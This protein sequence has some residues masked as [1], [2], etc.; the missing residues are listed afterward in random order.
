M[1][2]VASAVMH[3]EVKSVPP[4]MTLAD[5]ET[6]LVS[7]GVSGFAVVDDGKLIGV[8]SRS[9]VLRALRPGYDI[10]QIPVSDD[11]DDNVEPAAA[12]V[13]D[14]LGERAQQ[15]LVRDIMTADVVTVAPGDHLHEVADRMYKKRIHR[16]FV[17]QQDQLV[18]I[19]TPFDFVRLYSKDWIGADGRP[20]RTQDF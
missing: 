17:V 3:K 8:V 10:A 14:T 5:L 15:V 18:G 6:R 19:I 16:I 2:L 1:D 4:T 20:S 13:A 12:R 11:D 9:D 7:D